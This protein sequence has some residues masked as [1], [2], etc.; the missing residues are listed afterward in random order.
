MGLEQR[1]AGDRARLNLAWFDNRYSNIISTTVTSFTPFTSQYFNLGLT[2]ARGLELS[3]DVALVSGFRA[4]AGYTFTDSEIL[5]SASDSEVF[6]AGN[7][8]FRRPRHSGF[9][10]VAWNG[11]RVSVNLVGTFVGERVDSDFSALEP[12]ITVNE[13]YARWDLRAAVRLTRL[14]SVT[15]AI[16]NLADHDY[17]EPLGYPALGLAAR[18]GVRIGF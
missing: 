13:G 2:E 6:Q 18:G 17:M 9:A 12:P 3:G 5:E 16:D 14:I 1:L 10:D 7:S 8:A 11:S 15:G 4:R